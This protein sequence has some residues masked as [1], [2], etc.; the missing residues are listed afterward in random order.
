MLNIKYALTILIL[1]FNFIQPIY[2]GPPFNTDD[3]EP[4]PFKHWEYYISSIDRFQPKAWSGTLPHFEVNYGIIPDVQLHILMPV[5]YSYVS[6]QPPTFGYA[7]T[8]VGFKYCFIKETSNRPQ[9]GTFP[10]FEIPTVKND[11]FSDGNIKVFLPVWVQKSWDK[12]TTYGG[13]GY[14]INPGKNNKNS[15]FSGWEIQ[16]DFSQIVSLGGELY[17][18]TPDI[19][20]DKS[21]TGF[22]IGGSIN[23]SQKTHFI[24]SFGHSLTNDN[25]FSS[26]VGIL[27]TI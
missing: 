13:I 20:G 22:N 14:W 6:P 19:V 1:F 27:W 2:A 21:T 18:Q 8:E 25:F 5:N 7:N 3:P 10:I 16:Y 26:Y 11:E 4:V 15:I 23:F 9:I 17:Y 12:L 24:F